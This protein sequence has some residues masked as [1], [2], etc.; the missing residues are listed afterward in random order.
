[1]KFR[2][3]NTIFFFLLAFLLG[4]CSSTSELKREPASN[5]AAEVLK[6][7][8][9]KQLIGPL[10]DDSFVLS[11]SDWEPDMLARQERL[12]LDTFEALRTDPEWQRFISRNEQSD[13][14]REMAFVIL[15]LMRKRFPKISEDR[16]KDRYKV[17]MAF[18]G[19]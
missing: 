18:C 12:E 5:P 3:S 9:C 6:D 11:R 15:S 4:A 14:E 7:D 10:L 2:S 13:E 1:M 8:S 19:A 16:L 17:F